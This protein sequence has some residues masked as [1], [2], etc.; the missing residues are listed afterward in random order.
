MA[1]KS[2]ILCQTPEC[3]KAIEEYGEHYHGVHDG[4]TSEYRARCERCGAK[5]YGATDVWVSR[6]S[7]CQK[8]V[9]AGELVGLFVPHLCTECLDETRKEQ[10]KK[11]EICKLCKS[12][13]ADCCC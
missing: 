6:C 9:K 10:R 8:I 12:V 5:Y 4:R 13:Y 3:I 1:E 11:G 2:D 7:K